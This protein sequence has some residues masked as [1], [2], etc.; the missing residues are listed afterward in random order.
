MTRDRV[1]CA[2]LPGATEDHPLGDDVAV[3][4]VDGKMF[5]SRLP[6]SQRA[7]LLGHDGPLGGTA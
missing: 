1:L 3:V 5:G 7:R 4:K 6:R 2:R